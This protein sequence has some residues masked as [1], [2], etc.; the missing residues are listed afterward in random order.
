M[1]DVPTAHQLQQFSIHLDRLYLF[2]NCEASRTP[3]AGGP[4]N[5]PHLMK[6]KLSLLF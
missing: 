1:A 2:S 4:A 3:I 5:L 6:T